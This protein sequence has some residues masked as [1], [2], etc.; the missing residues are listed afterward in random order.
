MDGAHRQSTSDLAEQLK[1]KAWEYSFFQLVELFL[2]DKAI[3]VE[4]RSLHRQENTGVMFRVDPSLGFPAGDVVGVKTRS[5]ADGL[6]PDVT[7]ITLNFMGLHGTS[8]P[9][10]SHML[11][12]AAWSAGEEGVQVAFNDFFSNRLAWLLYMIWRKYRYDIRYETG[13]TDQFSGWMFSL[14]GVGEAE[15]RGQ[16]DIPW[17][18]LL[19]YLGVIAGRVRS[20][21]MIKGVVRHAFGL[22]NVELRQCELRQVTIPE[23]Q[24]ARLGQ[25]NSRSGFDFLIGTTKRDRAAK[26]TLVFYDL[27]FNRFRDFLPSGKDFSPLLQLVEFL[28]RD[29]LPWDLELHMVS[30]QRPQFEIGREDRSNLGWTTFTGNVMQNSAKPVVLCA[31]A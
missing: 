14:V 16:A 12:T 24:C 30:E 21:E 2:R 23:D 26:F 6:A 9:L 18:K 31:R 1:G 7:E 25:A 4:E 27:D 8:S 22:E 29:Q 28:L 10:P 5:A 17:P 20:P 11:E 3:K 15:M 19:T 13:A